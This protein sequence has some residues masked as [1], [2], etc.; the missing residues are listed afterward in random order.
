M[1]INIIQLVQGALTESVLQ[2]LATRIGVAPES[3]KR[4]V[5]LV[6]PALVG[7]LMNKAASP[8]GARG[9]FAAVMS[10]DT[11][12]NIIEQLPSLVQGDGLQKL[13]GMGTRLVGA[14]APAE[15]L[16]ALAGS[17][18]T[19]TGVAASATHALTGVV[20]T[21]L[22]GVLK[23]YFT[24]HNGAAG[25]LPTLLG[26]QLPF[27]KPALNDS[28]TSALGL[29]S[30]GSF[31]SGVGAQMKAV[32][33]H[34]EH[35]SAQNARVSA[36]N[37][38]VDKIVVQEKA[39]KKKWWWLAVLA[40]LALLAL[41]LGRGCVGEKQQPA[42][43]PA[44]ASDAASAVA[45]SAAPEASAASAAPAAMAAAPASEVAS[46]PAVVPTKDALLTFSVDKA[47]VPT[48]NATVGSEAEK[49]TLLDAL[50]AKFGEGKFTANVTVDPE[51]KPA[52][53]LDK[54]NGLLPLM[55]LPGAEVKLT[56][57]KIEL[58]G[59][60]ADAKLGWLDKLKNLFGAGFTIGTFDVKQA[61]ASAKDSFMNAFSAFKS[62]DC[63]AT[64]VAKVL[65]L[66][67]INF[68]TGSDVPPQDAQLALAK[69]AELLKTCTTAGKTVKMEIGG[70]SD[71]VGRAETNLAL[72]K[73]RAEAVR[74]FLVKHGVPADSL[75]PQGYGD[76]NPVAD[77]STASGRFANR[78]IEFKGQE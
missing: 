4:V 72:S 23:H 68:A 9:L 76:A 63:A 32:S 35:P 55:A 69:S 53:W 39:S 24:Q 34:L 26:H 13:L 65:N 10:P 19:Q 52:S 47:G 66:Q 25:A 15:R 58:S 70:Y 7:S 64:D 17:V 12:A 38:S 51:T 21:I 16:E 49:K 71:N 73:K 2:Q 11:N 29:G 27:V 1:S 75:T 50:T 30:A 28:I 44:A 46:Q 41:L 33:S 74:A 56:G 57:E 78:R 62:D 60:A 31:L 37:S 40:A 43:E 45:A 48:L 5:G 6:A 61:V 54:L 77:N 22:L 36:V 59:T 67:V 3:A 20:G 18:A 8:E 42:A 14:V